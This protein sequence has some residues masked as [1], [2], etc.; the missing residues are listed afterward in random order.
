MCVTKRKQ[1]NA[2]SAATASTELTANS[3]TPTPTPEA[4]KNAKSI[5][6]KEKEK[7]VAK[8]AN[9][10]EPE[11]AK[12]K[13]SEDKLKGSGEKSREKASELKN[14]DRS[15]ETPKPPAVQPPRKFTAKR[16]VDGMRE[17]KDPAYAT[18]ED[19]V[20]KFEKAS[21]KGMKSNENTK[22]EGTQPSSSEEKKRASCENTGA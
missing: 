15:A 18:L 20:P 4:S 11:Q 8:A 5:D 10:K 12:S 13:T 17:P 3:L 16:E 14:A 7:S 19:D 9:S 1:R 6:E 2:M 21:L 22:L